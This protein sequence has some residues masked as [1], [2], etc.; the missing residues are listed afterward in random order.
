MANDPDFAFWRIKFWRPAPGS[1][2][3]AIEK[4]DFGDFFWR[5]L[6]IRQIRQSFLLWR[7]LVVNFNQ[8]L[9]TEF[10]EFSMNRKLLQS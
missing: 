10:N 1:R 4:A 8:I 6:T 9:C 5:M 3:T 2:I 7:I